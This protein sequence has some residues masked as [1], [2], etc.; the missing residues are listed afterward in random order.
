MSWRSLLVR[1]HRPRVTIVQQLT[2]CASIKPD[3]VERGPEVTPKR[4]SVSSDRSAQDAN[5]WN[6]TSPRRRRL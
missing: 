1:I 4:A 3:P 6:C 2:R 5:L